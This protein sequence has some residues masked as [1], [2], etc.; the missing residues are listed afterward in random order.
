MFKELSNL[1]CSWVIPRRILACASP[2]NT[3]SKEY[4]SQTPKQLIPVFKQIGIRA[5]IRLNEPLY[6]S[7]EFECNGITLYDLE[8]PD[9]SCPSDAIICKFTEIVEEYER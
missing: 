6:Y 8:F 1:D 2:T 4:P 5:I 7:K 9:G 3:Y